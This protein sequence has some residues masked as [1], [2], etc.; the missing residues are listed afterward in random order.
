MTTD[1]DRFGTVE[2]TP[3]GG[4]IRFDR[5]LAYPVEQVWAAI[6]EPERLAD[7]W[8]PFETEITA[9]LRVGGTISFTW[10][11][12][13]PFEFT[14]LRFEPP[15][16]LETTHTSPGAWQRWELEPTADGTHLRTTYF[17]TDPD[18]AIER[19]DIVGLHYGL[20]RLEP[21]LAGTPVPVDME[22][23]GALLAAYAER[24]LKATQ[25]G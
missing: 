19:G 24:G 7:W 2:R 5:Q 13:P 10:P 11:D 15:T 17:L 3:D 9:D 18:L 23:F 8:T 21:A 12:S 4:V 6:T 25:L 22:A 20:D 16:L 14:I 1:T